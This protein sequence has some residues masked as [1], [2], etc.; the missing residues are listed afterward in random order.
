[1]IQD[2][3]IGG[4]GDGEIGHAMRLKREDIRSKRLATVSREM[5]ISIYQTK[6]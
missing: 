2:I 3:Y 4:K 6:T 1:M 5:E